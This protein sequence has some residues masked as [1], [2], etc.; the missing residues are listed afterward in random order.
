MRTL[1]LFRT[2]AA[3]AAALCMACPA[4]GADEPAPPPPVPAVEDA[5]P[6]DVAASAETSSLKEQISASLIDLS[7]LQKAAEEQLNRTQERMSLDDVVQLALKQNPEIIIASMEPGK[8]SADVYTAAGVFDPM[9]QLSLKRARALAATNSQIQA[10]TGVKT[11]GST[12]DEGVVGIGGKLHYGTQYALQGTWGDEESSYGNIGKQYN[13]M[14]GLTLTQPVLRGFGKKYNT[15]RI[16]QARNMRTMSVAQV[17]LT[18]LKTVGDVIKSYWNLVGAVEVVKVAKE[19]LL[20]A[21]RLMQI[22]EAR[23]RIGTAADIEVLQSKAGVAVR[24][25]EVISAS[26]RSTDASDLLKQQLV[27]RDGEFFSKAII[28]PT[29]RPNP[30]NGG[31]FD[32]TN[33]D[34]SLDASVKRALVNRPEITM[35]DME[36][37]NS[38]LEVYK[39]RNEMM[40]QL[41]VVGVYGQGG[42]DDTLG[43][44]LQ[45]IW[46]KQNFSYSI[47][48]Q[49]AVAINNR[50]ARGA[51]TRARITE[52]QSEERRKQTEVALQTAV[53]VAA[54]NVKTNQI[55]VESNRQAV[56][57]Q[58]ANVTAEEKRLRLG[59]TTSFQ[60]LRVQEDLTT[61]RLQE[62][63]ALISYE[64]ALVDLQIADGSLLDN[65]G[66]KLEVSDTETPVGYWESIRPRWE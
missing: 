58:E 66:I 61:A 18:M 62:L 32:F 45:G 47:G 23:R 64:T 6:A 25:S 20:N 39:S 42:R 17:K 26:T 46:D 24:Q 57:L 5:S 40:P 34:E 2:L 56:R 54:R 21:E 19:S 12:T 1:K 4:F 27:M 10:I 50:S 13:S 29:D 33:F 44:A 51:N 41:D 8:A 65:L 15:V 36:L 31:L 7:A 16:E 30:S 53:H 59:V 22:N 14:L 60:V 28:V 63:R 38:Q 11:I 48:M 52:R 49:G 3:G 43:R 37:A 9:L 55:L 35:S